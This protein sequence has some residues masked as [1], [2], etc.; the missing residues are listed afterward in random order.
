MSGDER[1]RHTR[2]LKGSDTSFQLLCIAK[3]QAVASISAP[4][5]LLAVTQSMRTCRR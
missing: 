2:Q 4:Q 3:A 5:F 1:P